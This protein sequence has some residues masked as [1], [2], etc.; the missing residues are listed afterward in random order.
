MDQQTSVD[1][2][3]IRQRAWIEYREPETTRVDHPVWVA[4]DQQSG[5][6]AIGDVRIEAVGNLV[7]AVDEYERSG[8]DTPLL[9]ARGQSIPRRLGR[10]NR[11][12]P[13][14]DRLIPWR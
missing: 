11:T 9:K 12:A 4:E 5:C 13:L 2:E 14:I 10:E 8:T 6:L 1:A 7:A 3:T